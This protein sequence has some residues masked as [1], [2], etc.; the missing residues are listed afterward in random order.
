MRGTPRLRPA[1]DLLARVPLEH[2]GSVVDLGCGAGALFPA[3]VAR[4]PEARITGVDVSP[5]MLAKARSADERVE[6]VEADAAT[7]RP[8]APVD[9]IIANAA[10]HWVPGHERLLPDLFRHCRVLAVQV[11]SNFA[12]PSHRLI[13]ELAREP[14]WR[15]ALAGLQLG[16]HVLEPAAYHALLTGAGA[17]VDLWETIYHH[18]LTGEDPVLDWLRGTTLLPVHAALGGADSTQ[19]KAFEQELGARLRLAYPAGPGGV[20]LFPFKRLF[21][22]AS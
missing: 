20:T 10:L 13:Q 7:W 6:L 12:A 8:Q 9:L 17:S 19:T 5:A 11:P 18:V 1:L 2:A 15:H 21:F 16:D 3:L 4:F 22:V 14:A